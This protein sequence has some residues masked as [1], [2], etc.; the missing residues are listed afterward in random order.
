MKI[1][2]EFDS[3]KELLDF[4]ST[5]GDRGLQVKEIIQP[6]QLNKVS[7][8]NVTSST[9][10]KE[11]ST[12][13]EDHKP[14]EVNKEESKKDDAKTESKNEDAKVTKEMV[15]AVFTKLIKAG[16]AKE[17]KELTLK[18]GANKLPEVKEEDYVAIYKEAEGLL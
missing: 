9:T 13:E 6:K 3:N 1:T 5:F 4:I 11:K 16:K 8:E 15:R 18:Y 7:K 14:I 2:A 17:A 12:K 10:N